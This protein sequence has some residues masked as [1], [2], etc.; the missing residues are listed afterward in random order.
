V[1]LSLRASIRSWPLSRPFRIAYET[2]TCIDTVLVELSDGTVTGRGEA[3]GVSYHGETA[4]GLLAQ[5]QAATALVEGGASRRDLL[6]ALP[7]GGAR[8]ALDCALW[9]LEARRSGEPV[10]RRAGLAALK[11]VRT[12]FTLGLAEIE[13]T[14]EHA[15]RAVAEGMRRLKLKLDGRDDEGLVAAVRRAAPGALLVVDANQ[16]WSKDHL[17]D[18]PPALARLGVELIEQ[19]VPAGDD[20]A[21]AGVP[22][23]VPFCADESCQTAAD[24]E[25]LR[26]LYGYVNI[27]L[28]KTGGLTEA[29][30][31]ARRAQAAGLGLMVGNMC[32]SSLAMA[33]GFVVAQLCQLVDLD[34]PLLN[35]ADWPDGFRYE[36]ELMTPAAP[37]FWGD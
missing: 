15:A 30:E 36:G 24:V 31:L 8:N 23:P 14:A 2:F 17:R 29:L 27:K 3:A 4:E 19:P 21:L 18:L 10:W 1:A 20:E 11:P 22:A 25:R 12:V 34:G 26:G 35:A 33:P 7:P 32:G 5:V 16:S 13:E 6:A 28:D 9:D 37:G